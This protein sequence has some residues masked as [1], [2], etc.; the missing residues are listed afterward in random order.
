M[1]RQRFWLLIFF[2]FVLLAFGVFEAKAQTGITPGQI[3]LAAN[4]FSELTGAAYVNVIISGSF[5]RVR[6][7]PEFVF[8]LENGEAV[9]RP[10]ISAPPAPKPVFETLSI[11]AALTPTSTLS[12]GAA[13]IDPK[14][15]RYF[16]NG[17]LQTENFDFAFDAGTGGLTLAVDSTVQTGDT[18]TIFWLKP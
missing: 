4:P 1:I 17:I 5:Y 15:I 6:F 2:L 8:A 16:R 18:V 9:V 11:P 3:R 10:V 7:G 14:T 12:L 13:G